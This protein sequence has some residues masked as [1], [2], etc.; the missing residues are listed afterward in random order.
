MTPASVKITI[1]VD[2]H[3]GDGLLA[4]H[5]LSL[6]IE[7]EGKHILFDTGQGRA[8][9]S[10]AEILGIDL[11]QTDT[12]VLSHGHFDHSGGISQVL[13]QAQNAD[14]YCHPGVVSPRYAIRNGTPKSIQMPPKS[15]TAIDRL[16]SQH[17]HWVQQ[18]IILFGKI[19]ITGPIPRETIYEDTGGP[20]YLD[21]EGRRP[22]PI[23]DDLALWIRTEKGL[24]VCVG[25]A[26]AGLVNTLN[27]VRHLSNGP[28]VRAIMGGFH[29]LGASQDRLLQTV[30]ALRL[31]KPDRVVPCHCTGEP[32]VAS[33][34]NA[35][36]E[37]VSPGAAGRTYQF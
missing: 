31:L 15:M 37:R 19:G 12:I 34:F 20:F 32:A 4:E 17:V 16:P 33:L 14:I 7:T 23:E 28:S 18:P 8:L 36:E 27:H 22:D 9:E 11:S 21:P 35:F 10:N 13:Q 25:C 24:I 1:L 6:W 2:N 30:A 3:A 26:H 5:G 29:L